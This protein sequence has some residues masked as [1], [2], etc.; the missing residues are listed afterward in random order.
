MCFLCTKQANLSEMVQLK[1][2]FAWGINQ[3]LTWNMHISFPF[4]KIM[5]NMEIFHVLKINSPLRNSS[6]FKLRELK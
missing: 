6:R 5:V 4:A 2:T 3:L 1:G